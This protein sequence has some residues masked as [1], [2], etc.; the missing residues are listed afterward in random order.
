MYN[1]YV[2]GR[3]GLVKY[4]VNLKEERKR[5]IKQIGNRKQIIVVNLIILVIKLNVIGVN[6]FFERVGELIIEFRNVFFI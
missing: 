6:I 5:N 4:L 2:R 3:K 1:Y